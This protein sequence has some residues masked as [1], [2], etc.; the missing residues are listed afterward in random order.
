[1]HNMDM[2]L[3]VNLFIADPQYINNV[4]ALYCLIGAK[5]PVVVIVQNLCYVVHSLLCAYL[6]KCI[7]S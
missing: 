2:S 1:M 3:K 7:I 4:I 5:N 6:Q